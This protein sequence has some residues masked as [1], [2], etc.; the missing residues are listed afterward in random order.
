M[1]GMKGCI[2]SL[3]IQG[4]RDYQEDAFGQLDGIDGRD[5][6]CL[7][8]VADGM[9]GHVG[10]DV[11]SSIVVETF[12]KTYLGISGTP[13]GRLRA[14]LDAANMAITAAVADRPEL[15]SMGSTVVAVAISG[16]ELHWASVGDSPMWIFREGQLMHINADHS[17]VP[18]LAGMVAEGYMTEEEAAK[19]SRRHMLRSVIMGDDIPLVDV[20]E[21]PVRLELGDWLLLASDGVMTLD[22]QMIADILE[23]TPAAAVQDAATALIR[24]VEDAK[25]PRQDNTTVSLYA[26]AAA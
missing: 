6:H 24:A 1:N 19:D 21:D 20:S 7:L 14:C 3:Q 17:M 11:A 4:G 8:V 15:D 23:D 9:G 18:V 5:D 12:L 26:V 16:Q 10:G 2:A 25:H 13:P 22:E